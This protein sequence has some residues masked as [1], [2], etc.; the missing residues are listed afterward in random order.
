MHVRSRLLCS[1]LVR[2]LTRSEH[3][4][5]PAATPGSPLR[6]PCRPRRPTSSRIARPTGAK[7]PWLAT[8]RIILHSGGLRRAFAALD[9]NEVGR[10]EQECQ[11]WR[12]HQSGELEL[13]ESRLG[14]MKAHCA[15]HWMLPSHNRLRLEL[16]RLDRHHREKLRRALVGIRSRTWTL[17]DAT[18]T[19]GDT[20]GHGQ[21]SR[22][23]LHDRPLSHSPVLR[24]RQ[25]QTQKGRGL[26]EIRPQL[27]G[28]G[29]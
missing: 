17:Q 14:A 7:S 10:M 16:A 15:G 12:R 25:P 28:P 18:P 21:T 23:P 3:T 24:K 9:A 29:E 4:G 19:A 26:P 11:N 8:L 13:A 2:E 6:P 22:P 5:V 20:T 1:A 27:D